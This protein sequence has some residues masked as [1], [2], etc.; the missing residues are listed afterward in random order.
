[1][2]ASAYTICH[3]VIVRRAYNQAS[4]LF[5]Q[6]I[7]SRGPESGP[8]APP[9]PLHSEQVQTFKTFVWVI[10]LKEYI[11]QYICKLMILDPC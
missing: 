7:Q 9:G 4:E 11:S 8:Q 6:L 3:I 1:M 2:K 5:A 10:S